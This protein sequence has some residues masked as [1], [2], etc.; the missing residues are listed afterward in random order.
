MKL[1]K[2]VVMLTG[3]SH[4]LDKKLAKAMGADVCITK[5][6]RLKDLEKTIGK[7]SKNPK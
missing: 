1:H 7:F 2:R 3:P 5:P 4:E 6:F